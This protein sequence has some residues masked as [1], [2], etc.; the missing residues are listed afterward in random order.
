VFANEEVLV[1]ESI[2]EKFVTKGLEDSI[3]L[4]TDAISTKGINKPLEDSTSYADEISTK[5]FGKALNSS[6]FVM[7][8]DISSKEFGKLL[9][10][11]QLMSDNGNG[12][13]LRDF[14]KRLDDYPVI[15]EMPYLS[16]TKYIDPTISGVD[17]VT[18]TD[19][20]FIILNP[21]AEAGWFA[22]QYV[23]TP[24]NF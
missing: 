19:V 2:A 21:Y 13:F 24:L 15:T 17:E 11:V 9:E 16:M 5:A 3:S 4:P 14:G 22:E 8:E 10:D 6:N 20:G 23:G 7:S 18:Q 12:N 1:D